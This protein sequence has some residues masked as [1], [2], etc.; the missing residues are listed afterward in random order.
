MG[1]WR[2]WQIDNVVS[3]FLESCEKGMREVFLRRLIHLLEY[4]DQTGRPLSAPLGKGL[5]ELRGRAR[6][7]Q[8]R[9]IY[10]FGDRKEIFFVHACYKK[11][12]KLSPGDL[13]IADRNRE[14]IKKE[15]GLAHGIDFA[16]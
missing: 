9:L 14:Q 3:S 7:S 4:G 6:K 12:S 15:R 13:A 10:F 5:F 11:R 16:N 8:A 1:E 2:L